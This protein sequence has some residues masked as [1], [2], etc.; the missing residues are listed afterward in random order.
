MTKS[1]RLSLFKHLIPNT[2]SFFSSLFRPYPSP[3]LSRSKSAFA[4]MHIAD[5]IRQ[6]GKLWWG[7]STS[8]PVIVSKSID[9]PLA[10]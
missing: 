10:S 8:L 2:Y 7:C 6:E 1:F 5:S 3:A 9:V 4:S